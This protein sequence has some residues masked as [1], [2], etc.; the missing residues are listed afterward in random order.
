MEKIA[1]L[2]RMFTDSSKTNG[3]EQS[4]ILHGIVEN[5]KTRENV[6]NELRDSLSPE[7][8]SIADQLVAIQRN[9]TLS[10]NEK[11]DI[12]EDVLGSLTKQAKKALEGFESLFQSKSKVKV[13]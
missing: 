13:Q 10:D 2:S 9:K 1:D 7:Y 3:L 8:K 5:E 4:E 6:M 12:Q 11:L